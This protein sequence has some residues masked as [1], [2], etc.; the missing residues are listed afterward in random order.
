[1]RPPALVDDAMREVFTR[2]PADDPR[3]L[4]HAAA[5]CR[6]WRGILT[7]PGF[8][9]GYR[10]F[11]GAAPMLGFLH[12]AYC[13]PNRF[14][15]TSTFRRWGS[16]DRRGCHVLDSRHGIVLLYSPAYDVPFHACDLVTNNWWEIEAD[17]KC[18][19]LMH[20]WPHF[21]NDRGIHFTATVL[22]AKDRCRCDHLDCHGGP[23]LLALVGSADK[24]GIALATAYSS[25]TCQWSDK[26]SLQSPGLQIDNEGHTAVVGNKVYVPSYDC[27]SVVEYNIREQQLSVIKVPEILGQGYLDLIGAED[28]MLLF[29]SV[30][31]PRLYLW[32]MEAGPRGAAAWARRRVVELEPLLPHR[33][34]LDMSDSDVWAAGFAEGVSVIF[35]RT[36]AGLYTIELNSGRVN[37][38]GESRIEKVMPYTSFCTRAWRRVLASDEASPPLVGAS[39]LFS[40][41]KT[42]KMSS[43]G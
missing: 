4:V 2:L 38:V 28:G 43:G 20:W 32:S 3:S 6:S 42:L 41:R 27:D 25:E 40:L 13:A 31:K 19:D 8:A 35:L 17:P 9:R 37:K 5:V 18:H 12:N 14:V 11:H 24:G 10:A 29:A 15:P 33:A 39:I 26:I 23:F 16:Q 36:P 1:M 7:D 34:L 30:L 21:Y 22:C